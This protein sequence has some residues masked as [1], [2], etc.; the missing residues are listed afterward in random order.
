LFYI[1]LTEGQSARKIIYGNQKDKDGD[2][3]ILVD[4]PEQNLVAK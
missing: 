2:L 1:R 4:L 3:T